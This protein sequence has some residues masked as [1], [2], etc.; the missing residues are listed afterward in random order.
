MTIMIDIN[1][2]L[3]HLVDCLNFIRVSRELRCKAAESLQVARGT[4]TAL[5]QNV[6]PP[7]STVDPTPIKTVGH[8]YAKIVGANVCIR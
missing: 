5:T 6:L 4:A 1:N 3:E 2:G 8:I 7:V